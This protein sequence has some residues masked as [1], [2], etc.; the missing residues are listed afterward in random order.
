MQAE[1]SCIFQDLHHNPH[2]SN[3]SQL[4]EL[5]RWSMKTVNMDKLGSRGYNPEELAIEWTLSSHCASKECTAI[6]VAYSQVRLDLDPKRQ[7]GYRQKL[8]RWG[9]GEAWKH[10]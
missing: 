4:P 2:N 3:N 8:G 7:A 5:S 6:H 1:A 10:S 9:W